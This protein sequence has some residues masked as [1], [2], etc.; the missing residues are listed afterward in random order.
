LYSRFLLSDAACWDRVRLLNKALAEPS[1]E[2]R[3]LLR[4][5]RTSR[6]YGKKCREKSAH[7]CPKFSAEDNGRYKL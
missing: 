4:T 6:P 5:S 7:G 1:I 3:K 2:L